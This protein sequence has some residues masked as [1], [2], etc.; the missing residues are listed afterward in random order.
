MAAYD[1]WKTVAKSPLVT[2]RFLWNNNFS[3]TNGLLSKAHLEV[4][5]QN[6][7]TYTFDFSIAYTYQTGDNM[8]KANVKLWY[9]DGKLP[10]INL[11]FDAQIYRN[12]SDDGGVSYMKGLKGETRE[13]FIKGGSKVWQY[14]MRPFLTSDFNED[15]VINTFTTL[16]I[17]GNNPKEKLKGKKTTIAGLIK[18]LCFNDELSDVKI[19]C[20]GR[21]FPCHKLILS[22][23]SDVFK[24]MFLSDL[25]VMEN[26]DNILEIPNI[27]ADIMQTFL[28]FLYQDEIAPEDITCDL[29]IAADQYNLKSLVDIGLKYLEN[30]INPTNVMEIAATAYLLNQDELIQSASKFIFNNKGKDKF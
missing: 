4:T 11:G 8:A 23:R 15:G 30:N 19:R 10:Q 13:N 29:L 25:K 1:A 24:A 3:I 21:D 2:G 22:A 27:S 17:A 5:D 7:D 20:D 16:Y 14:E 26:N 18:G 6:D 28:E 9:T 12:Y